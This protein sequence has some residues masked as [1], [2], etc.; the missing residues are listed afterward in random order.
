MLQHNLTPN[1]FKIGHKK[2]SYNC[3]TA[4]NTANVII[5]S[6]YSRI[7]IVTSRY[8]PSVIIFCWQ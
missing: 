7:I 8:K 2:H 5:L 6:N 1:T 4:H 3:Y